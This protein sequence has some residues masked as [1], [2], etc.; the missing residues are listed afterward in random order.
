M[1]RDH[2]ERLADSLE[3]SANGLMGELQAVRDSV[4]ELYILLE[5]MWRNRQELHDILAGIMEKR[6]EDSAEVT[7]CVH[8]D[9]SSP[10]LAEAVKA[11]W[12]AF[13]HDPSD[14]WDY[15]GICPECAREQTKLE[16]DP[17][18]HDT[19]SFPYDDAL[20]MGLTREQIAQAKAEGVTTLL[21]LRRVEK[22]SRGRENPEQTACDRSEA[23]PPASLAA[24]VQEGAM[25]IQRNG[26][27]GAN[28]PRE[29][30][31]CATQE[32]RESES[33]EAVEEDTGQGK[34]LFDTSGW[35]EKGKGRRSQRR[36]RSGGF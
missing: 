6:A 36:R 16:P 34:L 3:T 4:E 27:E 29:C 32:A 33:H 22:N 12:T 18:A 1:T 23:D 24:G 9:A 17:T 10:S 2:S 35:Q 7:C 25:R 11:G 26:P 28:E 21:G 30:Q 20:A 14:G 15:L 19:E 8:C 13:Q 31:D 5:H